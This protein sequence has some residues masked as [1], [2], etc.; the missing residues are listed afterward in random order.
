MKH[1]ILLI[2]SLIIS[3]SGVAKNNAKNVFEEYKKSHHLQCDDSLYIYKF[4]T[5]ATSS[6]SPELEK[7]YTWYYNNAIHTSK[8]NY[9]GKL[10]NGT[11]TKLDKRTNE[12]VEKGSFTFGKKDGAW[13]NWGKNGELQAYTEYKNGTPHGSFI[14]YTDG[15]QF[16]EKGSYQNGLKTKTWTTYEEGVV[17]NTT[18]YKNGLKDG[19][20]T[21]YDKNGNIEKV[22]HYKKG[23]LDGKCYL[24]KDN[25]VVSKEVYKNGELKKEKKHIVRKFIKKL[26]K[27]KEKAEKSEDVKK[28]KEAKR[29]EKAEKRE[30]RK[31]EKIEKREQKKKEKIEKREQ[32][33]KAKSAK[34][35]TGKK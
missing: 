5:E 22:E 10:L 29:A 20:S 26:F 24:Y 1:N 27:K 6:I 9:S 28:A 21:T 12:L 18:N 35:K 15:K 8:G 23:E 19:K 16:A 11:F 3:L 14:Q 25:K 7:S 34:E 30:Q 32:K 4:V 17:I 33:K 13:Y 2:I 31:K